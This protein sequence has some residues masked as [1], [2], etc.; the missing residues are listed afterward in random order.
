MN[1]HTCRCFQKHL[2]MLLQSLRALCLAPGGSGSIWKYLEALVGCPGV[3]GRIGCCFRT[4]LYFPDAGVKNEV[5]DPLSHCADFRWE[6]CNLISQEVTAAG[7]WVDDIKED[8]IDDEWFGPITHSLANPSP[9]T[10]CG[11]CL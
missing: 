3:S 9:L 10:G 8:I 4:N 11:G 1:L 5:I 2:K 7:E 6:R